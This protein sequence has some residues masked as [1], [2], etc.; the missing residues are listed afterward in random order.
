MLIPSSINH[1]LGQQLQALA[2]A[3]L[4]NALVQTNSNIEVK[5]TQQV[6]AAKSGVSQTTVS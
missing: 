2:L 3:E 4:S 1:D 6:A 5:I